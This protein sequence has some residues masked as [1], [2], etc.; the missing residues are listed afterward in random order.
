MVVLVVLLSAAKVSVRA[1]PE[2]EEEDEEGEV[3]VGR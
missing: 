3:V 1:L 2:D